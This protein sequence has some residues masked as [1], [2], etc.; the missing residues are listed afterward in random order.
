MHP[1]RDVYD[2]IGLSERQEIQRVL[3]LTKDADRFDHVRD[4]THIAIFIRRCGSRVK[5]RSE[6]G[7]N[8]DRSPE[9]CRKPGRKESSALRVRRRHNFPPKVDL[10]A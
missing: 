7:Q 8:E 2:R 10:N 5:H 3:D 6:N 9:T 4:L 1:S